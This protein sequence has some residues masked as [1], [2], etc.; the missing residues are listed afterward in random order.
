MIGSEGR[1]WFGFSFFVY[2][3]IEWVGFLWRIFFV[4][5]G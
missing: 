4:V 1:V 2:I 3:V 5:L